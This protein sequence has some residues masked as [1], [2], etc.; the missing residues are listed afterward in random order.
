LP[1]GGRLKD[2]GKHLVL[3]NCSMDSH[4]DR[5]HPPAKW[6]QRY[7]FRPIHHR[8]DGQAMQA[9]RLIQLISRRERFGQAAF[10]QLPPVMI[11]TG[12]NWFA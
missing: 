2:T 11:A 12:A 1:E 7:G 10:L 6:R 9:R 4:T 5:T 3:V 8:R